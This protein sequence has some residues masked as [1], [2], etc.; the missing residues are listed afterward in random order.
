MAETLLAD[1]DIGAEQ[2][3][4]GQFLDGKADGFRCLVETAIANLLAAD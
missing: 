2:E 4:F 1:L 3:R